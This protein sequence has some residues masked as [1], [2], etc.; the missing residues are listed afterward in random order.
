MPR[1]LV[2]TRKR[3]IILQRLGYSLKDINRRLEEEGFK[4]SLRSLQRLMAKFNKMHTVQDLPRAPKH[5]L[6]SPEMLSAID[7]SLDND[8]ELTARKLKA[9]L[10]ERY[11][12]IPDVSLST[13]KRYNYMDT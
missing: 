4:I 8:D 3:V 2:S 10:R 12:D 7:E 6:F 11:P 13:L 9:R 5:R 1:L